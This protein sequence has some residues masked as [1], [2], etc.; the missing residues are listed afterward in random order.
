MSL[1]HLPE[2]LLD[3]NDSMLA[4]IGQPLDKQQ[5]DRNGSLGVKY[6]LQ[7]GYAQDVF[8]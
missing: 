3:A 4:A 8:T 2:P 5:I 6:I 7:L 1:L